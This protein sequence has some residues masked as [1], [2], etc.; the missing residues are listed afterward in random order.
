MSV[1]KTF[2]RNSRLMLFL[3]CRAQSC[4]FAFRLAHL[5]PNTQKLVKRATKHIA[6]GQALRLTYDHLYFIT[7][8]RRA[9]SLSKTA[10]SQNGEDDKAT[11]SCFND[12]VGLLFN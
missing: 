1:L 9:I 2:K 4:H 11:Q 10:L 5:K 7:D 12:D 8:V 3:N 6:Y